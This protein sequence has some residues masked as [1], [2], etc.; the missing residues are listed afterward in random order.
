MNFTTEEIKEILD[1]QLKNAEV[2]EN[3]Y[4]RRTEHGTEFALRFLCD[5]ELYGCKY[6]LN[7][8]TRTIVTSS[9]KKI[10]CMY[11]VLVDNLLMKNDERSVVL[12][13]SRVEAREYGKRLKRQNEKWCVDTA[14]MFC[15][16]VEEVTL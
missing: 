11:V 3:N 8:K 15:H 7:E 4:V 6:I 2:A 14:I 13:D 16:H 1:G 9:V 5:G 10:A 12:F